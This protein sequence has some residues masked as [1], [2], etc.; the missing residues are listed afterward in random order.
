M[1]VRELKAYLFYEMFL[2]WGSDE[3]WFKHA[4]VFYICQAYTHTL[5]VWAGWATVSM[6]VKDKSKLVLDFDEDI[7]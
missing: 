5:R 2:K 3:D 1:N 6:Y 4:L 7:L